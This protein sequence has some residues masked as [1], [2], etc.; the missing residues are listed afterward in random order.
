[1][2]GKRTFFTLIFCIF[3]INIVKG[4]DPSLS[5]ATWPAGVMDA[6][7]KLENYYGVHPEAKV[8]F[9]FFLSFF[10]KGI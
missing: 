1:M 10:A 6:L 8:C 2:E 9:I 7:V 5:P 4:Q 3:F